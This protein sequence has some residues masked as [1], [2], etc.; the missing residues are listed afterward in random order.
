MDTLEPLLREH[1]FFANLNPEFIKL[2]AGCASNRV[3]TEGKYLFHSGEEANEFYI[4]RTGSIA[5][6]SVVS[7]WES[8]TI[9]TFGGGSIIG[10]SWLLPPYYWH[11]DA[12]VISNVRLIALDGRCIRNKCEQDAQLGYELLK[13]F[14]HIMQSRLEATQL[15]LLDIYAKPAIF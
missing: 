2:L 11:F 8:I 14:A 7:D 9:Q 13:R 5:L 10:W 1:P 6:E 4:I 15:Q 12:K 3:Y